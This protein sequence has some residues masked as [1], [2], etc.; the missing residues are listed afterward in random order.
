M[1]EADEELVYGRD[2]GKIIKPRSE[3]N[4][5]LEKIAEEEFHIPCEVEIFAEVLKYSREGP[6]FDQFTLIIEA[7][8]MMKFQ[9]IDSNG[10]AKR[11]GF[12]NMKYVSKEEYVPYTPPDINS[13]HPAQE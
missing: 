13:S 5:R 12:E 9:R 6:K 7:K 8:Y 4:A 1:G 11:Y 10:F 2:F 3:L